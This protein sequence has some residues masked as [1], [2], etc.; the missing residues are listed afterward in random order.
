MHGIE[1]KIRTLFLRALIVG[2]GAVALLSAGSL[3]F[4]MWKSTATFQKMSGQSVEA[5]NRTLTGEMN[6]QAVRYAD[7]CSE[8]ID[9]KLGRTEALLQMISGRVQKLYEER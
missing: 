2:I 5:V 4:L 7:S 1:E 8:I 6:A 3:G 9:Q